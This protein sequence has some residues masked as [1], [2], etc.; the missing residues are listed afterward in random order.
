MVRFEMMFLILA[1]ILLAT[2]IE[3][4]GNLSTDDT[5]LTSKL[6]L[7]AISIANSYIEKVTGNSLY[8]DEYTKSHSVQPRIANPADS[9][10]QL[11]NLSTT[12]GKDAGETTISTFDDVDDFNNYDD[13]VG[14]VGAGLFHVRC[15]VRY[16]DPVAGSETVAKTWFKLLTV[17]VTDTIP[18]SSIHYLQ[19]HDEPAEIHKSVVLSYFNFL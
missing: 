19:F 17:V 14:V 8:F 6:G 2:L 18:G 5:V 4:G 11:A 9:A 1:G 15:F 3:H 13:T 10:G 7:N 12:L 16:Y